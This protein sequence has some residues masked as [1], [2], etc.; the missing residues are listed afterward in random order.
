M[1]THNLSITCKI[2]ASL[3]VISLPTSFVLA[4][5]FADEI[6]RSKIAVFNESV[7]GY[8]FGYELI[9][10]N[11]IGVPLESLNYVYDIDQQTFVETEVEEDDDLILTVNGWV[12]F[13]EDYSI[14]ELA[15]SMFTIANSVGEIL[16]I[17]GVPVD[18]T[19]QT[20]AEIIQQFGQSLNDE[21][22]R[23]ETLNWLAHLDPSFSFTGEAALYNVDFKSL[24]D[25][26]YMYLTRDCAGQISNGCG[27][28][29]MENNGHAE[30]AMSSLDEMFSELEWDGQDSNELLSTTIA[31]G[32]AGA[33]KVEFVEA[34]APSG[35]VN[36]YYQNYAQNSTRKVAFG[37]WQRE[38]KMDTELVLL[39]LGDDLIT[40]VK[41][42]VDLEDS[43]LLFSVF[44]GYV[45][46]GSYILAGQGEQESH[47]LLMNMTALEQLT[48]NF[49][50]VDSDNDGT[51]NHDDEDDDNDGVYDEDDDFPLLA[52]E[53]D[54]TDG[55]GVG[56]NQD[57]DDDGDGVVDDQD[58]APL[59]NRVTAALDFT[60]A[61]LSAEYIQI[62]R[63]TSANPNISLSS[64]DNGAVFQFNNDGSFIESFPDGYVETT[65][66]ITN[67]ILTIP[68][69]DSSS[70]FYD[71]Q[72]LVDEG[73]VSQGNADAFIAQYDDIQIE[74]N[75][76]DVETILQLL[77]NTN[78]DDRFW[79]SSLSRYQIVNDDYR[80]TLLGDVDAN[81]I[82]IYDDG[83]EVVVTQTDSLLQIPFVAND[84][85][86]LWALPVFEDLQNEFNGLEGIAV[87]LITF[88]DNNTASGAIFQ[89]D[90]I[91]EI[92]DGTLILT[93]S[94]GAVITAQ[95][96]EQFDSG[97][98]V[99][100]TYT[101]PDETY[102]Y[103]QYS[104]VMPLTG[105]VSIEPLLNNFLMSGSVITDPY[106]YD[107]NNEILLERYF[108]I[109]LIDD[110]TGV[111]ITNG[112]FSLVNGLQFG[113]GWSAVLWDIDEA[114]E[115]H[116]DVNFSTTD[117]NFGC[118]VQLD[119]SCNVFLSWRLIPL[120]VS[121]DRLYSIVWQVQNDNAFTPNSEESLRFEIIPSVQFFEIFEL[122]MDGDST[123]DAADAFPKDTFEW[124]D[125]D[126]DNIGNNL[127]TDD[128]NDNVADLIDAFPLDPNESVDTD[129]DGIGNNA[130]TD[131]DGDGIPDNVD[132]DP[133]VFDEVDPNLYSGKVMILPDINADGVAEIGLLRVD[134]LE[135]KVRLEILNGKDRASL[136][137][138][139]WVDNFVD[140]SMSL[141]L[142]PDMNDNGFDEVGLFG[143]QDIQNNEGKP[144][145]FVRDL[146][147][148]NKVGD[149]YNWVANWTE[150][151]ALILDDMTG[152]GIS[153]I[154][155]QGRFFDGNRPQLIVK[156]G[157][158]NTILDT[159]SYPDLFV[160]PQYYQHSD[161]NGDGFK[162]IATFGRLSSNNKIQTKIASGLDAD[163]KSP[164]YNFPDKWANVSWHRLD[165]S[166][167]D[168]QDD[169]GMFGTLRSD[170]RPQ[171]VN[172][173]GVS[174]AGALRIFAWP[175]EMQNAQFFRIPDMNNDGVDEVAAAGR[176]S[177]NDRYQF[178][179]QDGTDRNVLL[180]NH[181]LNLDLESVTYHV[182]PDLSGDEKAEIGFL[183]INPEGE[184][185]LVI[186]HGDAANGE[187]ATYNLGSD[188][189][190]APAITSLGDT[191]DDGLP[192]L[193]IYGQNAS[194]EELVIT[195][196]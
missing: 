146:K 179:V 27:Y 10:F 63:G 175:A 149:V 137:E 185:E 186:R 29:Y 54:D 88:N 140:I 104:L 37:Q 195:D 72:S 101:S 192:D 144:Q 176:R 114:G 41:S 9:D 171:L 155:I 50:V 21:G 62:T 74:V 180:A 131:D 97:A 64:S 154:A 118:D 34:D 143:I 87:D 164:A 5:E 129:L 16:Q 193:L 177:N 173:D 153:E 57:D 45:R 188:W 18:I 81:P 172:K 4:Q 105:D 30:G 61:D 194:G 76:E 26:Y 78:T 93:Q 89:K 38:Q 6:T 132:D 166:N 40:A 3:L 181:N 69:L 163:N 36:F 28:T 127:D 73:I 59:N 65:W 24:V 19:E 43:Q 47:D 184:Y 79:A 159:Y 67:N 75:V 183:G 157:N 182:L 13:L 126:N 77:E 86:Q 44:D 83:Q 109:A 8:D 98:G 115:L 103:S 23:E 141:H 196:M 48:S 167:G 96:F 66:S 130:D 55:D 1:H 116:A 90:Y 70:E 119:E 136:D 33:L 147:T 106:A 53:W 42:L 14:T 122:D 123:I 39:A 139:V 32:E 80:E 161:I 162:E 17:N 121:D 22:D 113:N 135:S 138:I 60:P 134:V 133:L 151:S 108:G 124:L 165:D 174:P 68:N 92:V 85:V 112:N 49:A 107:E 94:N 100:T 117:G 84:L 125:S 7:Y 52:T 2:I 189:Q 191:D 158:T 31:W 150:V 111:G 142:I 187:Y 128:D 91:W 82:E 35:L 12:P 169:W 120:K 15:G 95:R 160:T 178:Q 71:V 46:N 148:G 152:D 156:I 20:A 145:V 51:L 168:G 25:A 190:S 110:G 102:T 58:L 11:T 99:S 170:G 56:N